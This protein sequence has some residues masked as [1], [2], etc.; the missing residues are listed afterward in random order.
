AL[1]R[2]RTREAIQGRG[3]DRT[4]YW[5]ACVLVKDFAL[6]VEQALP[7]LKEWNATNCKPP[8]NEADLLR[9]LRRAEQEPGRRSELLREA[10]GQ[11]VPTGSGASAEPAGAPFHVEVPD[12][13]LADWYCVRPRAKAVNRGPRSTVIQRFNALTRALIIGQRSTS[14]VVPDLL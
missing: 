14:V 12:F 3:G 11:S 2:L 13:I 8:W 10:T 7:L 6:S 1:A 5:A 9:K 4:T